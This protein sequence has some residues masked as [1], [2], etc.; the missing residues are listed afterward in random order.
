MREIE[1]MDIGPVERLTIPIPEEGGVVCLVG[2]NGSGKSLAC[3]AVQALLGNGKPVSRDGSLGAT[4]QGLGARLTVGRRASRSGELE[5][6]HLEG[7]DPSLLVDPGLKDPA[8]ADAQRI[9]TLLTLARAEVDP[10]EFAALVGGENQL[11]ELCRESS[12]AE[13]DIPAMAA[14]IKRD[15]EA[16]AR[17]Y[18]SESKNLGARARRASCKRSTI[19][20]SRRAPTSEVTG[21]CD[22]TGWGCQDGADVEWL[23]AEP[24]AGPG[25]DLM[26]ADLNGESL[27]QMRSDAV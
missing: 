18:E 12:L 4:V 7:Q 21:W 3:Q 2:S 19:C 6:A 26:P 20:S 24:E 8:A 17:K 15:L 13:R 10:L 1:I 9:R 16:A 5:I 23:D 27:A 22:Y 25:V 11:R 14:A